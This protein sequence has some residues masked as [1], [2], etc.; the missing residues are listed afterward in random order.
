MADN[1]GNTG[2]AFILG[3]VVV[4]VGILAW[5]FLGGD[6]PDGDGGADINIELEAPEGGGAEGGGS[7]GN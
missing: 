2:L 7:T 1:G 3:G 6:A 5:V 4:V